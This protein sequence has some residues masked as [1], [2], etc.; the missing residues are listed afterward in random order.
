[1]V[2]IV[3]FVGLSGAGKTT[4]LEQIVARLK[5]RGFRV[6]AIK[7]DVHGFDI[8]QVGKDSWRLRQAGC[9]LVVVSSSRRMALIQ[10]RS[11]EA[12]LEEIASLLENRAD[13]I[14]AEGYKHSDYAKIAVCRSTV[15]KSLFG[16]L[17]QLLAVVSD[18]EM[19]W[20]VPRFGFAE[21][22]P[23]VD[24]IVEHTIGSRTGAALRVPGKITPPS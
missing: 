18:Q 3:C 12:S 16:K 21:I 9:D 17:G 19:P 14:L 5:N 7:H 13:I 11:E 15:D 10:E 8:D 23:V 4:L 20:D 22:D 1:M 6:A 2:P 24:L